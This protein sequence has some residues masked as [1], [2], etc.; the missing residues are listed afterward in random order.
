MSFNLEHKKTNTMDSSF[1]GHNTAT[2]AYMDSTPDTRH[3]HYLPNNPQS[4]VNTNSASMS[5]QR[6]THMFSPSTGSRGGNAQQHHYKEYR[7]NYFEHLNYNI[8][9]QSNG[10]PQDQHVDDSDG[11]NAVSDPMTNS[12]GSNPPPALMNAAPS[13]EYASSLHH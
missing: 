8:V 7:K 12:L 5:G 1:G 13:I 3:S 10:E 9:K 2:M 6:S 11:A 4:H